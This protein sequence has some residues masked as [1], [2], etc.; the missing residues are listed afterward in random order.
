[1][2][3]GADPNVYHPVHGLERQP[4]ACFVGQRYADR[5]RWLAALTDA[6]VP[7]DIYGV[8]WGADEQPRAACVA[9]EPIYL[10]RK[11]LAPGT[12]SSYLQLILADI[13]QRGVLSGIRRS[14]RQAAYRRET[15]RLA[16][17]LQPRWKGHAA[18]LSNVFG[19]Y[20]ICLNLSNVWADGRP[21]SPLISHMRLRDFEA[22]MC[23]TCYLTA[24][25]Q[26]ITEFY[27]FGR[28]IDTYRDRCELV[29]KTRFYL[30]NPSAADRLR[31]AGY[32][33]ALRDHTWRHRF[34]E[35]FAKTDLKAS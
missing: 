18:Y 25:S 16:R 7:L 5:D 15:R 19:A 21:G 29:D 8:G 30:A 6:N 33:R 3:L 28:E 26:E 14:A 9:E 20:E 10:G 35:L 31:Q 4:K 32:H 1:V 23:R 12:L 17:K 13:Q 24:H 34:E 11:Q 2:Q 27:E 22:P